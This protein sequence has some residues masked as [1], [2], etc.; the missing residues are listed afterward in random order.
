MGRSRPLLRGGLSSKRGAADA[1]RSGCA[2]TPR[3]PQKLVARVGDGCRRDVGSAAFPTP[4]TTTQASCDS[5]LPA[6]ASVAFNQG[7]STLAHS[8]GL[9]C[10]QWEHILDGWF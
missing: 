7:L 8:T 2:W 3:F 1:A 4:G 6:V 10:R 5:E 9:A